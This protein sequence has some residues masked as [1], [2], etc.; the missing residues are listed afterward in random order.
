MYLHVSDVVLSLSMLF[1]IFS[2][3]SLY[4]FCHTKKGV[5]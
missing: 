1:E 3:I 4:T 2:Q 5:Y